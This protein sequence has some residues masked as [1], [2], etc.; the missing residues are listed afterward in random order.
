MGLT[1]ALTVGL[2]VALTVGLTVALTV[3]LTVGR[4]A[5]WAFGRTA[6]RV[7]G[8]IVADVSGLAMMAL[9][10]ELRCVI[11][12]FFSMDMEYLLGAEG[13]C[14]PAD[15]HPSA[16]WKPNFEATQLRQI[17]GLE[18]PVEI[19]RGIAINN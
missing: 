10:T 16:I 8:F 15:T 17:L 18:V 3:G 11:S 9:F 6:T 13:S 7:A 1:V 12:D 2:T 19:G 5:A 4:T 14:P